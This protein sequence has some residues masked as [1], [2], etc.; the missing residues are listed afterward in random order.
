MALEPGEVERMA[1]EVAR[2]FFDLGVRHAFAQGM[3]FGV[4]N[5]ELYKFL[6]AKLNKNLNAQWADVKQYHGF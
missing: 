6:H 5:R 4:S 1:H 2:E 3:D